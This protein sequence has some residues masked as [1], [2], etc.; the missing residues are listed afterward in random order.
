[1][2]FPS[3]ALAV[4]LAIML[5]ELML[6]RRN[7]RA[8]RERGAVEPAGDVFR[9]LAIIYPGMFVLMAIE[10]SLSGSASTAALVA[11]LAVLGA[12]KLLKL[13]A[14]LALGPRWSYRVLVLPGAPL[15]ATGAYIWLRRANYV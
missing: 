10:G 14:I 12:A 15:V 8:L 9:P 7:V 11:G 6:S 13:W 4:V 5:G 1:M 3:I 2:M